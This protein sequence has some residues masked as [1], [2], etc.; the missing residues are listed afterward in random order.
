M[1]YFDCRMGCLRFGCL[2]G[3]DCAILG[4]ELYLNGCIPRQFRKELVRALL[5][6]GIHATYVE[7]HSDYG[8]DA[9]LLEVDRLRELTRD[10]RAEGWR[11]GSSES[12]KRDGG[13]RC[14]FPC[15][16]RRLPNPC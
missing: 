16:R 6:S 15:V 10:S 8:H 9:F 12:V 5:R 3:S 7:I 2:S 11:K 1:D 13:V 14:V 4:G